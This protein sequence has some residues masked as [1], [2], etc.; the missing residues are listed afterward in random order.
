MQSALWFWVLFAVAGPQAL[1][2]FSGTRAIKE[3]PTIAGAFA[4]STGKK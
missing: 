3:L 4:F 2:T 1:G